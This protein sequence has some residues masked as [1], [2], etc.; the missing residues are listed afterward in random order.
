MLI[1]CEKVTYFSI[2]LLKP[3]VGPFCHKFSGLSCWQSKIVFKSID[4]LQVRDSVAS[5][6]ISPGSQG[7]YS[8]KLDGLV[9]LVFCSVLSSSMGTGAVGGMVLVIGMDSWRVDTS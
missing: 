6:W 1:E 4:H 8:L 9:P 5:I 3:M 7:W 2:C